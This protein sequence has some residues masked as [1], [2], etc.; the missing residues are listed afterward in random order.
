MKIAVGELLG[1]SFHSTAQPVENSGRAVKFVSVPAS[2]T[3]FAHDYGATWA[4][5]AS[6]TASNIAPTEVFN[7]LGCYPKNRERQ[8][9]G[10]ITAAK[11]P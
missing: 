7:R 10:P 5:Y 4:V 8:N 11:D 1:G 9:L 3:R 6:W 2:M